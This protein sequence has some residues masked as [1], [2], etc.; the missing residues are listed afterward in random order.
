MVQFFRNLMI[1]AVSTCFGVAW[2]TPVQ[3][4]SPLVST[5]W[6][7][8]HQH[9]VVLLDL[10]KDTKSFTAEPMPAIKVGGKVVKPKIKVKG[11]IPGATLVNYKGIRGKQQIGGRTVD[12]MILEK[13]AFE[14]VMR[15]AGVDNDSAVVIVT[16]GMS[17]E[18]LTM[19]T[20]LYWQLKYYGHDNVAILDGGVARWIGEDRPVTADTAEPVEGD[21]T[22]TA[23]R[24]ELLAASDE[25]A[26]AGKNGLVL[27]DSRPLSQYLG[28]AKRD[29]VSAYGH[30]AGAR[31]F[32][33]DLLTGQGP[34]EGFL[35]PDQY[36]R[37]GDMLGLD[38]SAGAITYC[39]SG[40]L[41]SGAWFIMSEL[42]GN[43]NVKVYD[44]SM[45]QW[46]L[47]QRPVAATARFRVE[48]I[49][50]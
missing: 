48:E 40:H 15:G 31:P 22:A 42:L 17:T 33:A 26:A 39:N 49:D 6:L 7:A 44:G 4:R 34:G 23:E 13:P 28:T 2:A 10:R 12:K 25:V 20:R 29:Y 47:E 21:W 19:G 1:V 24:A 45:H 16:K 38:L 14:A 3:V 41:A 32:P 5:E 50:E 9:E 11:H 46:T 18:D 8:E 30:I 36:R 43:E 35:A 37:L 27:V